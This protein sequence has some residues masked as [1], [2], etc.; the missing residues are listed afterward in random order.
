[1]AEDR[2]VK[3]FEITEKGISNTKNVSKEELENLK[4][5]IVIL[6]PEESEIAKNI[7]IKEKG[8]YG[9]RFR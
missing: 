1:M 8:V 4:G 7:G 9:V 3:I 6:K 5:K 2:F